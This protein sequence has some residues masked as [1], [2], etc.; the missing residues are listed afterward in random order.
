MLKA[1]RFIV[2]GMV[3]EVL[4]QPTAKESTMK[5]TRL[6]A[7]LL[8]GALV[9][10][11][12]LS[13]LAAGTP[14]CSS[15]T[16]TARVNYDVGGVGQTPIDGVAVPFN[17]ASKVNL[18][19]VT[20]NAAPGVTVV[21][22]TGTL[23][24]YLTFT[25][26]NDGNTV[27]DYSL[28][29]ITKGAAT[30]S[31][32][33]A[34]D[35]VDNFNAAGVSVFV[36]SGATV[37]YQ[38]AQ[39]TAT[40]IDELAP[41]G[42][43]T[44]YIVATGAPA[45]ALALSNGNKAVYALLAKTAQGGSAGSEGAETTT[46]LTAGVCG[47]P[48]VLADTAAGSGPAD[49]A[50]DGDDSAYSVFVVSSADIS[51]DK[52]ATT[53]WDPINYDISPKAIPGAIV[54][55]VVTIGNDPL[56]TSSA[57]LTTIGDTLIASLAIDPDLKTGALGTATPTPE[58]GPGKGFKAEVSGARTN[59]SAG[60]NSLAAGVAKYYTTTSSA[61]GVDIAGQAITATLATLL[62]IDAGGLGYTA[63]ELKPGETFTLTFNVVI[64]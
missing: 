31:V 44:V 30:Y 46:A 19:V 24:A 28:S 48:I 10:L 41:N 38:A 42:T 3:P 1:N 35:S 49:G 61:D 32:W 23:Q 9:A 64:Q 25:V 16:N 26:Q 56:A 51:I 54:Q 40:Y 60:A 18:T 52:V 11:S 37:G 34:N 8:A 14:V 39:D 4:S 43:K 36:E 53:L 57:T 62:P 29:A 2:M 5:R 6:T 45:I 21:P 20:T 59:S 55:Y 27:Q 50:L 58:S 15:I 22:G 33:A 63:G 17:V 47:A 13:A 7:L 12:S